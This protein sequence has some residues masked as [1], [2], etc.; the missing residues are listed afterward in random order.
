VNS[1]SKK[2]EATVALWPAQ[3]NVFGSKKRF[4]VL[5]AG[6]RFGKTELAMAELLNAALGDDKK[7]WYV[8][9]SYRRQSVLCGNG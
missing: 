5:V 7:V 2:L 1:D 9:P 8:A 3:M 6:R 4:R